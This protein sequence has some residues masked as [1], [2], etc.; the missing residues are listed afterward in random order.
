MVKEIAI[1]NRSRHIKACHK[2]LLGIGSTFNKLTVTSL[3]HDGRHWWYNCVCACGNT[4]KVRCQHIYSGE[5]ISCGCERNK[6]LPQT[7]QKLSASH[8]ANRSAT[9]MATVTPRK[10]LRELPKY[11]FQQKQR[12]ATEDMHIFGCF[13]LSGKAYYCGSGNPSSIPSIMRAVA[14][15]RM[16]LGI[17]SAEQAAAY[18]NT[19]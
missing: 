10:R 8:V 6:N 2:Y 14:K 19:F 16:E 3:E 1:Q 15:K 13:W 7:G 12:S 18:L 11:I 4:K 5:T 9:V 17:W